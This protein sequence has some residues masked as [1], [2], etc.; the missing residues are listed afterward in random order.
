MLWLPRQYDPVTAHSVFREEGE[1]NEDPG[2]R[3]LA[4]QE[5]GQQGEVG[6]GLQTAPLI[7]LADDAHQ[8]WAWKAAE[9][10][11]ASH[12]SGLAASGK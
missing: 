12:Q 11:K 9:L 7:S 4:A 2:G 3:Q 1:G 8:G 5:P 6:S 10:R